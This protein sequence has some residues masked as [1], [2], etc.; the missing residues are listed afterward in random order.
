MVF[1]LRIQWIID[2]N[3]LDELNSLLYGCL[4]AQRYFDDLMMFCLGF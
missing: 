2:G 3:S 4:M 1:N